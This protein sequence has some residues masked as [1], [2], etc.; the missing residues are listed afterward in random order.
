MVAEPE[1]ATLVGLKDPQ[2]KL[3]EWVRVKVTVP[4]NP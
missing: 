2:D 4:E 1:P 3:G